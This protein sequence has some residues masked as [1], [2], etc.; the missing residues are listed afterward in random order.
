MAGCRT[1]RPPIIYFNNDAATNNSDADAV[2]M[3]TDLEAGPRGKSLS[4]EEKEERGRW[5]PLESVGER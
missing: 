4:K 2:V 1:S 3:A 5:R